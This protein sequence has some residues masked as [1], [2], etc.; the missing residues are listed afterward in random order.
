[1]DNVALDARSVTFPENGHGEVVLVGT[2][3]V[4]VEPTATPAPAAAPTTQTVAFSMGAATQ[5]FGHQFQV[6]GSATYTPGSLAGPGK[7]PTAL[8]ASVSLD[9]VVDSVHHALGTVSTAD[10]AKDFT[11]AGLPSD[12]SV[13]GIAIPLPV[14]GGAHVVVRVVPVAASA[15]GSQ[16]QVVVEARVSLD[17]ALSANLGLAGASVYVHGSMLEASAVIDVTYT[18]GNVCASGSVSYS[19]P[20]ISA[21]ASGWVRACT[22][23]IPGW[24][25]IPGG[26]IFGR[27]WGATGC[28]PGVPEQCLNQS[29]DKDTGLVKGPSG[30]SATLFQSQCTAF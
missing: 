16:F 12:V 13:A 14:S 10:L 20:S 8:A 9:L 29:S 21:G 1:M 18:P 23:A 24:C 6:V 17:G 15:S 28:V 3:P 4:A 22:P 11:V 25:A 7:V 2:R 30:G 5:V 27:C 19:P 26:C